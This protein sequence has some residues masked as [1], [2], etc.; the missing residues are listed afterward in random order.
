MPQDCESKCEKCEEKPLK[1]S[2]RA[3]SNDPPNP[4]AKDGTGDESIIGVIMK[5]GVLGESGEGLD[6]HS[7]MKEVSMVNL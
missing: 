4:E 3:P 6:A 5:C 7:F 2:S 1:D